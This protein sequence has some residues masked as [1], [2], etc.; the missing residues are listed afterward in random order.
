[1]VLWIVGI[2]M[3]M[4]TNFQGHGAAFKVNVSS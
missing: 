3:L 1:M 4:P 2:Q